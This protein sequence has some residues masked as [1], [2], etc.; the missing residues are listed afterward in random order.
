MRVAKRPVHTTRNP[1][2]CD[3]LLSFEL[4]ARG[5]DLRAALDDFQEHYDNTRAHFG[6]RGSTPL[7]FKE[8]L[9]TKSQEEEALQ[10]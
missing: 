6:P 1:A 5:S 8:G 9:T 3:E 4:F 7:A 10:G 2:L